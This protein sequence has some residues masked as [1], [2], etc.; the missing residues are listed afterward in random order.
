MDKWTN[1]HNSLPTIQF[2][3]PAI[4]SKIRNENNT[5]NESSII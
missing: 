5:E 3:P 1:I 2:N 4:Q